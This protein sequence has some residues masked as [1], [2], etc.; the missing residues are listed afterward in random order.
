L[1]LKPLF[2]DITSRYN[3]K[4]ATRAR[5]SNAPPALTA[6]DPPMELDVLLSAVAVL[7]LDLLAVSELVE[8]ELSVV[9]AGEGSTLTTDVVV[10]ASLA[11]VPISSV[12]VVVGTA[13]SMTEEM[14]VTPVAAECAASATE[15]LDAIASLTSEMSH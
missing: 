1:L 10:A 4:T 11:E 5:P 8:L 2:L 7:V 13:V 6:D 12:A 14:L 15:Q 9:D 3:P